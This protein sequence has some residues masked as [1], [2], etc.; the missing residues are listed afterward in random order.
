MAGD[1]YCVSSRMT[2][3]SRTTFQN[4]QLQQVDANDDDEEEIHLSKRAVQIRANQLTRELHTH[5]DSLEAAR[6][7]GKKKDR[8]SGGS[9]SLLAA[10][11]HEGKENSAA[12]KEVQTGI[13]AFFSVS[14]PA[15]ET[16]KPALASE[17]QKPAEQVVDLCG[18]DV[19]VMEPKPNASGGSDSEVEVV[20]PPLPKPDAV[21]GSESSDVE[22]VSPPKQDAS[23]K[24][25]ESPSEA[26]S[27][28]RCSPEKKSK[29]EAI[30]PP[31]PNPDAVAR[32]ESS[33][34]EIT[35]PPPKQDGAAKRKE[36]PSEADSDA[37]CSPEKK[38]KLV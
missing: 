30:A 20:P 34:V 7:L 15:S 22:I 8:L 28:A 25:K 10:A 5:M 21:A 37:R 9:E 16:K 18:S 1:Y 36:S 2:A 13:E 23:A 4:H 19:E 12:G 14:K 6:M 24:R 11:A 17:K 27:E 33:D 38:S 31:P 29:V 32:S 35:S 3:C 26:D